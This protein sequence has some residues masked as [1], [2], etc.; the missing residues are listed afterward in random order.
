MLSGNQGGEVRR[1]TT[2]DTIFDL[3]YATPK[4]MDRS[5]VATHAL[6]PASRLR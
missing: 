3:V 2:K 6:N 4:A 1:E 5:A